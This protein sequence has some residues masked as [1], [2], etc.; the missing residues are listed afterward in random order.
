MEFGAL[1][2]S[3]WLTALQVDWAV[4]G[5]AH[6]AHLASEMLLK[7][8]GIF[9]NSPQGS[10]GTN[11]ATVV[12]RSPAL[13]HELVLKKAIEE[14]W[15]AAQT[16]LSCCMFQVFWPG[17]TRWK[18][19]RERWSWRSWGLGREV[20]LLPVQVA[21]C[22]IFY[23][24]SNQLLSTS[25]MTNISAVFHF[26]HF[27]H[28]CK[29]RNIWQLWR[30]SSWSNQEAESNKVCLTLSKSKSHLSVDLC[31]KVEGNTSQLLNNLF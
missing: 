15:E 28:I 9:F 16:N 17:W 27:L 21:K 7:V 29:I 26:L 10:A 12:A 4:I 14:R 11:S 22:Q 19:T 1:T 3:I 6:P 31:S 2:I 23:K 24:Y 25:E 18:R 8:Q 20:N 30:W 13:E 5:S